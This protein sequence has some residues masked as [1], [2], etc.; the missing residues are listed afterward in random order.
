M[1][2]A[3]AQ[4]MLAAKMKLDRERMELQQAYTNSGSPKIP[5]LTEP[6]R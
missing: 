4:Q 6:F 2:D 3:D 1:T 5:S